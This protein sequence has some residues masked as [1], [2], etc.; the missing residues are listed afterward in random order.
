MDLGFSLEG[1][2]FSKNLENFFDLFLGRS[3]L[4]S[5]H[6][7]KIIKTLFWP[8]FLRRR[9]NFEKK[10]KKCVLGH[11][12]DSFDHKIALFSERAPPQH[13]YILA[14]KAPLENF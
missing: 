1:S 9:Q 6:F 7:Q 11:F 12:L 2:G 8:K 13:K 5:E 10:D 4:F 14:P 3:N